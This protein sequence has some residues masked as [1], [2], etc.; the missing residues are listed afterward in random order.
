MSCVLRRLIEFKGQGSTSRAV[1]GNRKSEGCL[2]RTQGLN[3][4]STDLWEG[5]LEGGDARADRSRVAGGG[6]ET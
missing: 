2:G 4:R 5:D 1:V 3:S 6:G